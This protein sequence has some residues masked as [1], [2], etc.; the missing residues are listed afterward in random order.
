M[1]RLR[2]IRVTVPE[3]VV[4]RNPKLSEFRCSCGMGVAEEYK[5]C[6]YCGAE[7]DWNKAIKYL[8]ELL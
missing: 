8:T 4:Y 7:L 1:K 6:P 5:S 2:L 3:L